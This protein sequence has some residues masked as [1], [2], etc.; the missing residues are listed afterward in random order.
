MEMGGKLDDTIYSLLES[1]I[2]QWYEVFHN[3]YRIA[4]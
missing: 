1:H 2:D 4:E 3:N